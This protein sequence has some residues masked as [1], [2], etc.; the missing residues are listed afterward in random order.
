MGSSQ[1]DTTHHHHQRFFQKVKPF[2]LWDHVRFSQRSSSH[3][4]RQKAQIRRI[5][6]KVTLYGSLKHLSCPLACWWWPENRRV[7][8][9]PTTPRSWGGMILT[10]ETNSEFTPENWMAK[11]GPNPFLL[12]RERAY[13]QGQC[14]IVSGRV[15][16]LNHSTKVVDE[17]KIGRVCCWNQNC[18]RNVS[19]KDTDKASEGEAWDRF[20]R[21]FLGWWM[22]KIPSERIH[23]AGSHVMK[24]CPI[25]RPSWCLVNA[26]IF[27]YTLHSHG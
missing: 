4:W 12:G 19:L 17:K 10:L 11:E 14:L 9:N 2:K 7:P 3:F 20:L 27:L 16:L 15:I 5:S 21:H 6:P 23:S 24:W 1:I 26:C 22:W 18:L 8:S 13:F 25:E